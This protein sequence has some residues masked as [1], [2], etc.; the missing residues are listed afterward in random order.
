MRTIPFKHDYDKLR[1]D[2]FTTIRGRSFAVRVG[3]EVQ[4][5]SPSRS[6][7]AVVAG[8]DERAVRDIPLSVLEED[9]RGVA[10][11]A[12]AADFV[13]FANSLRTGFMPKMEEGSAVKVITLRRWEG[14]ELL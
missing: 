2:L 5:E 3:E 11:V 14:R 4:V 8:V 1:G 13:R 9:V 6:F 12:V 10:K 7:R